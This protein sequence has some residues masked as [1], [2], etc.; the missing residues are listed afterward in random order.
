V[1][2]FAIGSALLMQVSEGERDAD[3]PQTCV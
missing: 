2:S 3:L 1:N